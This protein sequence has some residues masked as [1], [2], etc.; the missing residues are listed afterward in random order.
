M[1]WWI[2]KQI[3][4]F[5]VVMVVMQIIVPFVSKLFWPPK[6]G[7]LVEP[8]QGLKFIKGTEFEVPNTK[9]K[10][11]TVLE[12]WATWCGPCVKGIP[13]I[14]E[15][16]KKFPQVSF[17]GV[18]QEKDEAVVQAFVKQMGDKMDYAVAI[19]ARGAI[20]KVVSD[21]GGMGI[22]HAIIIGV[23]GKMLWAGHPMSPDFEVQIE[24]ALKAE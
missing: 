13:H 14:T 18:T 9:E 4:I 5:L 3:V 15:V 2:A 7:S 12:H 22:P 11:V 8:I 21:S 20:K 23:D 10:K 19:D 1:F 17:V 24:A 6:F 16:A